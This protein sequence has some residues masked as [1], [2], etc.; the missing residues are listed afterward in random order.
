MPTRSPAACWSPGV[1]LAGLPGGVLHVLPGDAQPGA[2]L[3]EKPD[4]AMI[5]SPAPP[6]WAASSARRGRTLKR[7]SL[8][9]G[10]NNALIVLT[11]PTSTSPVRPA[12]GA[13]LHEGQYA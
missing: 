9:L 13:I 3:A 4:V 2:A 5:S 6:R 8:E 1:E 7:V 12:R 10:G 11:T